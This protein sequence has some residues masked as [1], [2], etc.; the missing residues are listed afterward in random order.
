M[1]RAIP[2]LFAFDTDWKKGNVVEK[3]QE[4][5]DQEAL[6]GRPATPA[7]VAICVAG[8]G[9]R[10]QDRVNKNWQAWPV[11]GEYEEVLGFLAGIM[12]GYK[13]VASTRKRPNLGRY[14]VQ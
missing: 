13:D 6:A 11:R 7:L 5:L 14:I 9:Y 2:A 10:Y 8:V 12:N 4:F 3:Y 1:W